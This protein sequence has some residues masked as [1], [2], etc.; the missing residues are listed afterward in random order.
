MSAFWE[1]F[2]WQGTWVIV[3]SIG[4]IPI[5]T[6]IAVFALALSR[7][8]AGWVRPAEIAP[9]YIGAVTLL[10]AL[11]ASLMM[12]D[13]WHRE[14][15]MGHLVQEEASRLRTVVDLS[16][17]CGPPCEGVRDAAQDYAR[18]LAA[19][20][21]RREWVKLSPDADT[22]LSRV[23][24]ALAGLDRSATAEASTQGSF[25]TIYSELRRLRSERYGILYFDMAPHRWAM[26]IVLGVLTQLVLASLH[27]GRRNAL[28]VVLTLFTL[29]FVATLAYMAAL[30]W[31]GADQSVIS[32]EDMR[33]LLAP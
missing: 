19:G 22:A 32:P 10:F 11:F 9:P 2:I 21:W 30:V 17:L 15:H 1:W 28:V 29:A 13:I 16:E 6:G 8:V 31:P 18:T 24:A 27:V 5:L 12:G 14:S 4:A 26:I 25:M 20:E 33:R 3:L 7:P 23:L